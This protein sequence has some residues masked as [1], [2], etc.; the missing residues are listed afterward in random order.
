L[1]RG[2]ADFHFGALAHGHSFFPRRRDPKL[3]PGD[4][5]EVPQS[6]F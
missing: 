6:F 1:S 5:I 2:C 3:Q 4:K